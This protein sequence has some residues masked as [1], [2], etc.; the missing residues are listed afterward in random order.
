MRWMKGAPREDPPSPKENVET[1]DAPP[2]SYGK[3]VDLNT[4]FHNSPTF[5]KLQKHPEA[6]K[7][8]LGLAEMLTEKGMSDSRRQ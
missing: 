1:L 3:P 6:L 4:R 2:P 8:L 7:L 5:Y